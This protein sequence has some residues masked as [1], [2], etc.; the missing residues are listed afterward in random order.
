MLSIEV[1]LLNKVHSKLE[2]YSDGKEK[3][4]MYKLSRCLCERASE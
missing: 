2:T 4:E 1:K 3:K